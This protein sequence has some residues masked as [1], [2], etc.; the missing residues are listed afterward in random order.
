MKSSLQSFFFGVTTILFVQV[1]I[2]SAQP[3]LKPSI[4]LHQPPKDQD[5]ICPMVFNIDTAYR[6]EATGLHNGDTIPGFTLYTIKDERVDITEVLKSGKPALLIGGS[7]T[8]PIFR[9]KRE[10]INQLQA[11]YGNRVSIFV[12]Y[13]EEAHPKGPDV[14]PN[15]GNVWTL[16]ANIK[17]NILYLQ[18]RTYGD[19][20]QAASDMLAV[21]DLHV[22]LLLDGPCN[23]WWTTFG[24]A[25]NSAFLIAPN[26]ILVHKQ[27][28]LNGGSAPMS[29]Y[30]D[31][32][33]NSLNKSASTLSQNKV[34]LDQSADSAIK[35][36]L[37]KEVANA[38]ISIFDRYGRDPYGANSFSGK[39][40]VMD[41]TSFSAGK[42]L[43]EIRTGEE[44]L[45]GQFMITKKKR[46]SDESSVSK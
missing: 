46:T 12:V 39:E 4:G 21:R 27:G 7:Y 14:S 9:Q 33:L 3:V 38:V 1:I 37:D 30:I 36:L 10:K 15:S 23:Q 17:K 19:R 25:P 8:C 45:I 22:P 32:L 34:T 20:R 24:V 16:E 44:V 13:T 6:Y 28:W 29:F 40:Y 41:A 31:S 2:A 42:F 43:Y 35:F 26:G 5:S 18:P 11:M